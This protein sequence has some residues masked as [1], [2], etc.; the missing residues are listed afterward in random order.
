[1]VMRGW[2]AAWILLTVALLAAPT[3]AADPQLSAVTV[4]PATARVG[5]TITIAF[6]LTNP[7]KTRSPAG[8]VLVRAGVQEIGKLAT[9]A[10][11]PGGSAQVSG[12]LTVPAGLSGA[13]RLDLIF[14]GA[15]QPAATASLT[16]AAAP[17][18]AAPRALQGGTP[19]A[20]AIALPRSRDL[21][22]PT[23]IGRSAPRS[24]DLAGPA[25]VGAP[26][27][28]SRD[29]TGP[30]FV[31]AP[32]Q[33]SRDLT[34]PAFIGAAAQRSRDLTGANFVGAPNP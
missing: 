6:R 34:G 28:R 16:I 3:R 5:E 23:F 31:G 30:A 8:T 1:M 4:S 10:V 13:V 24:R 12:R 7:E 17:T 11:S 27:L 33:R 20:P 19:R 9:P 22:G 15:A 21:A 26:A 14:S 25:F 18:R 32:A 29:L 2:L